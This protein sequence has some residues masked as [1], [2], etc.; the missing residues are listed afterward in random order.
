M[1][2]EVRH[3]GP[4]EPALIARLWHDAW[5]DSHG[6]IVPLSL[7]RAR[8]PAEFVRRT[9]RSLGPMRITGPEG[10]PTGLCIVRGHELDQ[11]YVAKAARGTGA[12]DA[13][14]ADAEA[15]LPAGPAFLIVAERNAR[16]MRFYERHGW[17]RVRAEI[18][19]A[20]LSD[21]RGHPLKVIRYEK[22]IR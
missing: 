2:H 10:A 11:I 5:H 13:L 9:Y 15:R 6:G 14:M 20:R 17:T 1:S 19:E 7:V 3:P 4:G 12:A 21:G 22:A 18:G 16:A 8:T